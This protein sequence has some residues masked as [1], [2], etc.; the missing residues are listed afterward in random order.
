V[1]TDLRCL[2]LHIYY[3]S[4]PAFVRS[5]PI[6]SASEILLSTVVNSPVSAIVAR[7]ERRDD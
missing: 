3:L 5:H 7:L 4:V 6:A 1:E 2:D